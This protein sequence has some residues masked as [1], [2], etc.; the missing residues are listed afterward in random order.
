[1]LFDHHID[2]TRLDGK[3]EDEGDFGYLNVSN[4][5]EAAEV[6]NF[7]ESCLKHYPKE[8]SAELIQRMRKSDI[9]FASASFELFLHTC[10]LQI[11]W[12]IEVHPK[13]PGE[14]AKRPDFRVYTDTGDAFYVEAT[15]ARK[16][17]DDELAAER[18][19]KEVLRA[20]NDMPS[21]YFL[22]DID[23]YGSPR[24]SVPRKNLRHQI[25]K[26]LELLNIDQ[27]EAQIQARLPREELRYEHDGWSMVFKAIPR[28]YQGDNRSHRTIAV[29]TLSVRAVNI[30]DAV[31]SAAKSK[32]SR[33]GDLDLPLIVAINMEEEFADI[34]QERDALFGD[35]QFWIPRDPSQDRPHPIRRRNG[36]WNGPNGPQC[37]R[38][39]GIWLF[40]RYDPWHFVV[41]DSNLLYL[42]PWATRPVPTS[43]LRFPYAM[44]ENDR[45]VEREGLK[46]G[47]LFNL[48]ANWPMGVIEAG[49]LA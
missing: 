48:D 45:L 26:W 7:L 32:A 6:R 27:V 42:N 21:P 29:Q 13:V 39:S 12:T 17:S 28:K 5:P 37:T 30:V 31:K 44:V 19:K 10:F 25:R 49:N 43:A 11:G 15:L 35:L 33:Y 22:L 38:L 47:S 18:R 1:M 16:F 4:R 2:R 14:I 24:T 34:T 9:Q 20:I 36:V 23:F 3:R 46:F 40:R 41:R 8:H